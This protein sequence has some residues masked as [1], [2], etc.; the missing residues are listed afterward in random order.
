[1]AAIRQ[2]QATVI[3]RRF[4]ALMLDAERAISS[5]KLTVA[6]DQEKLATDQAEVN[7]ATATEA[8]AAGHLRSSQA[9]LNVATDARQRATDRLSEDHAQLRGVELGVYTG[10]LPAPQTYVL[11][12]FA[13]A[14]T[15]A[16][17]I[18]EA[19]VIAHLARAHLSI[20]VKEVAAYSRQE[21]QL[22]AAVSAGAHTLGSAHDRTEAASSRVPLAAAA[23][24]RAQQQLAASDRRLTSVQA[25]EKAT[26]AAVGV[27]GAGPP[28]L[29]ILGGSAL[30]AD[31]LAAWFTAQG[32][33]NLTSAPITQLA[34]WYLAAGV[35]EGVRGDVAFAQAVL[36]T[37]GFSS[38]DAV[39][40]NNFAGIGHCDSCSQGM[41]FPSVEIGVFGQVE[42][43]H[44]FATGGIAPNPALTLVG[45]AVQGCCPTWESLTH[46][47]ATDPTYSTQILTLYAGM[48][49]Q[50]SA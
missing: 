17:D 42:L 3:T 11:H 30:N 9:A 47:W 26:L 41:S 50:A 14:Q 33:A 31:Q 25:T 2:A 16:I 49:E 36:E 12:T 34:N 38:V 15:A 48:L 39:D 5:S 18:G 32:Y 8:K 22:A 19:K 24:A 43:L 23:L 10:A 27:N 7:A 37:G 45:R 21:K 35:E 1:V 46:R 40:H 20:D 29:S 28:G 4:Q 13:T 44:V 6:T